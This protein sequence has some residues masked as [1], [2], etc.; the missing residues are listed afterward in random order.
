MLV[1]MIVIRDYE[2]LLI[3]EAKLSVALVDCREAKRH[4]SLRGCVKMCHAWRVGCEPG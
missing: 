3:S 1:R 2:L 4:Q